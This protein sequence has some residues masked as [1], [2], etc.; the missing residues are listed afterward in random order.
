[1]GLPEMSLFEQVSGRYEALVIQVPL[2]TAL[3]AMQKSDDL[4]DVIET[5]ACIER[6][7]LPT[8][9][10]MRSQSSLAASS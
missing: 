1:M 4:E 3:E 2:V 5:W 10:T 7:G 9:Q 8:S 6:H